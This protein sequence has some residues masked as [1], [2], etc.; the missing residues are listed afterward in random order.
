MSAVNRRTQRSAD[1]AGERAHGGA[2]SSKIRA[3]APA[4]RI[5][6][7][8]RE[9]QAVRHSG[10]RTEQHGDQDRVHTEQDTFTELQPSAARVSRR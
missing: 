6:Q 2:D 10:D 5:E 1:H 9:H 3:D 8:P 4:A 7:P